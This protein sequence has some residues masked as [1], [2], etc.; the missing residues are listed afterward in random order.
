MSDKC[1]KCGKS[2]PPIDVTDVSGIPAVHCGEMSHAARTHAVTLQHL[3]LAFDEILCLRRQL[4]AANERADKAERER[5]DLARWKR[6]MMEV[7]SQWTSA[8]NRWLN[9]HGGGSCE[10]AR[11]E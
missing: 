3:G 1:P 10:Q 11:R 9:K 8:C 2:H 6:S 5:D 7:E 4:A